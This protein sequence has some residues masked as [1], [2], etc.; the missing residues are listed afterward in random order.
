MFVE[1]NI[2]VTS[3]DLIKLFFKNKKSQ[4]QKHKIVF[5]T[6]DN[7][8]LDFHQLVNFATSIENE[9]KFTEFMRKIKK[10][11]SRK[12][13]EK[14]KGTSNSEV[15][16]NLNH[17]ITNDFNN[18]INDK[19]NLNT[20][21]EEKEDKMNNNDVIYLPMTFNKILEYFDNKGKIRTNINKIKNTIV[22]K[23]ILL[24]KCFF[25]N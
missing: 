22:I 18:E 12:K 13:G 7:F 4:Q 19:N 1:N 16:S 5:L 8:Y 3:E 25:F 6:E 9:T 14:Y 11:V 20:I 10:R 2:P 17:D 23:F 21:K 24:Y 15:A